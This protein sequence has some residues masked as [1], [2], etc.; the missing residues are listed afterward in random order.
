MENV[1][2]HSGGGGLAE[3]IFAYYLEW[4]RVAQTNMT[5]DEYYLHSS[6]SNSYCRLNFQKYAVFQ[7]KLNFKN[8]IIF[9]KKLN[10][11]S[12]A[13]SFETSPKF[14]TFIKPSTKEFYL[15]SVPFVQS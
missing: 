5:L 11:K 1:W 9:Q 2:T 3:I 12:I 15:S 6:I 8:Y 4:D 13:F 10:F 14:V 7:Y